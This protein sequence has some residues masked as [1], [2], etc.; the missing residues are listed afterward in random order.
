MKMHD[1]GP[2]F[3]RPASIDTSSGTLPDGDR[4]VDEHDGMSLRDWFAGQALAAIYEAAV[5]ERLPEKWREGLAAD[6][7][8][9]ADAML[10]V[11]QGK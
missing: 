2:A 5:K 8:M 1:G 7:Y 11:R 9:L 3:P 6:A 4:V 10:Y